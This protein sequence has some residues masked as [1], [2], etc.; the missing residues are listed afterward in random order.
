MQER[1]EV[2]VR[3]I[4]RARVDR[5]DG[6][7]AG[8]LVLR[9]AAPPVDGAANRAAQDLLG[10]ALGIRAADV[11]LELGTTTRD[12]VLSVPRGAGPA[13]ARLLK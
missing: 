3:V 6:I 9:V 10:K 8:R 11:R 2:R 7:R 5:V 1:I 4:P 13:L 12:K